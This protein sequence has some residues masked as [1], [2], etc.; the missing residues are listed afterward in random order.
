M[1]GWSLV[2]RFGPGSDEPPYGH[3]EQMRNLP[4]TCR[5][6]IFCAAH[7]PSAGRSQP[8]LLVGPLGIYTLRR[9]A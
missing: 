5:K 6:V 2:R 3:A 4:E 8:A 7:P 1:S 9:F